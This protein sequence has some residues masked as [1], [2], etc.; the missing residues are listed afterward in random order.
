MFA[1]VKGSMDLAGQVDAERWHEILD[2]F[3]VSLGNGFPC[4]IA[5]IM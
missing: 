2:G 3:F 1:D 5:E 4:S